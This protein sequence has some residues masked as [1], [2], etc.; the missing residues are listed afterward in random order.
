MADSRRPERRIIGTCTATST[1]CGGPS[2]ATL[3]AS[4]GL[5]LLRWA[6][7]HGALVI[8]DEYD[9]SPRREL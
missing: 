6:E 3:L 2:R 5:D 9:Y 4:R 8:E 1:R 7:H